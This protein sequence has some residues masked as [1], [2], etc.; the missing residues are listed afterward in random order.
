MGRVAHGHHD[1]QTRHD[2]GEELMYKPS[3]SSEAAVVLWFLTVILIACALSFAAGANHAVQKHED[4]YCPTP[5]A[6][7]I[8][9]GCRNGERWDE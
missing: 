9:K 7:N 4:M 2:E 3:D 8:P 5:F 1:S 6:P